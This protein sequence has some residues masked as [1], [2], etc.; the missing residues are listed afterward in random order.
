MGELISLE[1][2]KAHLRVGDSIHDD[3]V[4]AEKIKMA[5]S[6]AEDKTNRNLSA[7]FSAENLPPSIK[8]AVLLILGTL[9]DNESDTII[10]RS[11][12]ELPLSAMTILNRWRKLPY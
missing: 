8:A 9:Y 7:E 3:A 10:G 1:L 6:I 11:V 5:I 12:A 4:I 2:A